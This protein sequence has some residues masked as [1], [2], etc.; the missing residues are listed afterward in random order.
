MAIVAT[1]D[2]T[3]N[4]SEALNSL[5]HLSKRWKRQYSSASRH[6]L[7]LVDVIVQNETITRTYL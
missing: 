7:S 1:Y 6:V 2:D 5:T 3:G 4:R